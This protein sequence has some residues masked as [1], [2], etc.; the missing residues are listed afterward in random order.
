MGTIPTKRVII[1][2]TGNEGLINASDFDAALYQDL[3]EAQ[4]IAALKE[5]ATDDGGP[6]AGNAADSAAFVETITD[7][8]E[9]VALEEAEKAGKARKTV[10]AAID[11]RLAALDPPKEG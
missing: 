1:L 7:R 10:L 5:S 6:L 3:E 2:A 8:A 11:A 9:L 4:R